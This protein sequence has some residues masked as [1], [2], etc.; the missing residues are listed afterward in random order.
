[1]RDLPPIIDLI[2][3]DEKFISHL[4]AR[5]ILNDDG[6]LSLVPLPSATAEQRETI[7]SLRLEGSWREPQ[8]G[9][10]KRLPVTFPAN[11][12]PRCEVRV[13]VEGEGTTAIYRVVAFEDQMDELATLLPGD[14]VAIQGRLEIESKDRKLVGIFVIACQILALKKRSPNRLPVANAPRAAAL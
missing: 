8:P 10:F 3:D 9:V 13:R 4:P 14:C 1:M 12:R 2:D 6:T 5:A 7:A 11:G